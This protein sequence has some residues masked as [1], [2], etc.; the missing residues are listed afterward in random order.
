MPYSVHPVHM[1]LI[2]S[3]IGVRDEVIQAALLHDVVEDCE[4]W[5][6]AKLRDSFGEE[7]ATIVDELTEDKTKSWEERKRWAVEHVAVMSE[8][9][10]I[11][12]GAD[13]LHNLQSLALQLS[14]ATNT[15][16]VWEHFTGGRE[17]TLAMDG[18]LV[19]TLC[20]RLPRDLAILLR[21]ALRQVEDLA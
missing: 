13:K 5:T 4:E 19:T 21:E 10:V 11:V 8:A 7:V 17:R 16:E 15:S 1:A 20:E 3:R 6:L 12:K 9:S 2:L 14:Q 18:E